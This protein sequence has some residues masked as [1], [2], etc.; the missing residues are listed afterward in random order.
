MY[1]KDLMLVSICNLL[2]QTEAKCPYGEA[3]RE[4]ATLRNLFADGRPHPGKKR[5]RYKYN[6]GDITFTLRRVGSTRWRWEWRRS[7][8]LGY[9]FWVR[10]PY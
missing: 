7:W 1:A 2:A 10:T 5:L 3:R 8:S 4:D 9:G 6:R